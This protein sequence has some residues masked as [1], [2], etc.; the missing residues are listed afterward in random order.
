MHKP[1]KKYT[2]EGEI[3]D[4]SD[5][6]RLRGELERLIEQQMRDEGYLPVYELGSHWSTERL[7]GKYAFKLTM[8][9]CYAGKQKVSQYT[10]WQNGKL[11]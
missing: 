10:H 4:D 2:H 3:R 7:D 9:A 6:I 8:Y 11:V 1:I 5:F